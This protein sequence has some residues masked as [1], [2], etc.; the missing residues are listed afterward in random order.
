MSYGKKGF[1]SDQQDDAREGQN[2]RSSDRQASVLTLERLEAL[3]K[4]RGTD[5]ICRGHRLLP[6]ATRQPMSS[7]LGTPVSRRP[8]MNTVG[9]PLTFSAIAAFTSR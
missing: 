4:Q 9:V 2:R 7:V 6:A 5:F 1:D 3:E 8:S